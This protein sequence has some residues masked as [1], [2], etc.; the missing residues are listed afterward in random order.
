MYNEN[1][2][3]LRCVNGNLSVSLQMSKIWVPAAVVSSAPWLSSCTCDTRRHES[4]QRGFSVAG[5]GRMFWHLLPAPLIG[6]QVR[7][8]PPINTEE[9]EKNKDLFDEKKGRSWPNAEMCARTKFTRDYVLKQ[10]WTSFVE[11]EVDLDN[12]IQTKVGFSSAVAVTDRIWRL[13]RSR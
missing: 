7:R 8:V 3:L 2:R 10:F 11:R 13:G 4:P 9:W 12:A 6:G 1:C 5:Q